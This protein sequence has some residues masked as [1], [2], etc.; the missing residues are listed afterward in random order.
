MG[1]IRNF[2]G[3]STTTE[4]KIV[5]DLIEAALSSIQPSNVL[6]ISFKLDKN[7]LKINDKELNLLE[8]KRIFLVAFGKGSAGI[9]K[10]IE[11]SLGQKLT[12]GFCIDTKEENFDKI[13][14]TLGTHPLP[15]RENIQFTQKVLENLK[16]LTQQDLVLV[17]ICGGGSVMFELPFKITLEKL[18]EVNQTLLK[19]GATIFETNTIRKHLSR[20]KGGGLAKELLPAKLVSLIFSDVAGNDL[21]TIASGTTVEDPTTVEDALQIV[22]KYQMK[23]LLSENDF[24][25]SPKDKDIFRNV[26]NILMLSNLTA[27]NA[28]RDRANSLGI[29]VQILTNKFQSEAKK[30]AKSLIGKT[31]KG[32]ILLA[33]G[34]TTVKVN[35]LKGDGGRN[36]EVALSSLF[37]LDENT[38]LA[39][40][41]SDGWDNSEVAG[42]IVDYNSYLRAKE[43]GLSPEKFLNENNSLV[44]FKHLGDAIITGRLP[45]NVSDLYIVYKK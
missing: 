29:E 13:D 21:S 7:I 16:N 4:R 28:M 44:F 32:N 22:E 17:V 43:L 37:E 3:L 14:F 11:D 19:N 1:L 9:A 45:S 39:A 5:L 12:K 38:T 34:E 10:I 25:E 41:D 35:N 27:L 23:D 30:A 8:Y 24:I 26:D 18:I 42:A 40:F 33:G 20:V 36:Q 6:Q 2:S 31:K 15:S